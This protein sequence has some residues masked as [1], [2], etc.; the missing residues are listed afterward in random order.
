MINININKGL[1]HVYADNL[2]ITHLFSV[3]LPFRLYLLSWPVSHPFHKY[4]LTLVLDEYLDFYVMH[5]VF[6]G[7]SMYD[8]S[9]RGGRGGPGPGTGAPGAYPQHPSDNGGECTED[10]DEGGVTRGRFRL[11]DEG[12]HGQADE[13]AH[14]DPDTDTD[15]VLHWS[16]LGGVDV[17]ERR[18]IYRLCPGVTTPSRG[19]IDVAPRDGLG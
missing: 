12:L 14:H 9:G 4:L 7:G 2:K 3:H 5:F 16:P 17:G 18:E 13:A 11:S 15:P 19:W 1:K 8:Q 10:N 6:Q